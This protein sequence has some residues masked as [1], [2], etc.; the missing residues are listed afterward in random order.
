M[1]IG[2]GSAVGR[3]SCDHAG[4]EDSARAAA[5]AGRALA[6]AYV[7]VFHIMPTQRVPGIPDPQLSVTGA[8]ATMN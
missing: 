1:T 2:A 4:V 5:I 6:R 7:L 8:A 3:T